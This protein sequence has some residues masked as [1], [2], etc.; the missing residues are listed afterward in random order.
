M[1][2]IAL[3]REASSTRGV[4]HSLILGRGSAR[5]EDKATGR[6]RAVSAR[7]VLGHVD[8]QIDPSSRESGGPGDHAARDREAH[9]RSSARSL[10]HSRETVAWWKSRRHYVAPVR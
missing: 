10:G 1:C 6:T 8:F 9:I 7:C 2:E 4:G 3:L 5:L